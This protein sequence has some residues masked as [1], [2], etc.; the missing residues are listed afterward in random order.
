MRLLIDAMIV[1]AGFF[2]DKGVVFQIGNGRRIGAI[3][4]TVIINPVLFT[5]GYLVKQ[6]LPARHQHNRMIDAIKE[7]KAFPGLFNALQLSFTDFI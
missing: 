6:A 5:S 3:L 4:H 2:N 1:S 7:F